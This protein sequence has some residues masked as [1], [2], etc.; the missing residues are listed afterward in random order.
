MP[1]VNVEVELNQWLNSA[2]VEGQQ[3]PKML[4]LGPYFDLSWGFP[5][6]PLLLSLGHPC[7]RW[8]VTIRKYSSMAL[9]NRERH[10][11]QQTPPL[12]G[13]GTPISLKVPH[14]LFNLHRYHLVILWRFILFQK[15]ASKGDTSQSCQFILSSLCFIPPF[16]FPTAIPITFLR[17]PHILSC[18]EP[19]PCSS[20]L[21]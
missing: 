15:A 9:P 20:T 14:L 17:N 18:R 16:S 12:T 4:N 13:R 8:V 3:G 7:H 5:L 6:L 21:G 1:L 10:S 19:F 11:S 2:M